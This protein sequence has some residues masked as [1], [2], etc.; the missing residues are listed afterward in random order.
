VAAM[1]GL[2]SVGIQLLFDDFGASYPSLQ[3][4]KL[5]PPDQIKSDQSF[6]RDIATDPNDAAIVQFEASLRSG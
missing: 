5:L 4:L 6:V 1:K 2:K 3:F